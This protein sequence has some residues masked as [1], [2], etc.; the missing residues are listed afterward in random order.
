[1]CYFQVRDQLAAGKIQPNIPKDLQKWVF[2]DTVTF[3]H[4][5]NIF[6]RQYFEFIYKLC[7][8]I[9]GSIPAKDHAEA[10]SLSGQLGIS[11]MW[12]T[13]VHARDRLLL[14]SFLDL[15][16]KVALVQPSGINSP[17]SMCHQNTGSQHCIYFSGRMVLS[18]SG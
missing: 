11:F 6:D 16:S 17:F 3:I 2:D 13:L 9:P 10:M 15:M 14:N 8:T 18:S 1:M 5:T 7:A 12:E 4:D